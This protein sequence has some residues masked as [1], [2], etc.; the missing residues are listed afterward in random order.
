MKIHQRYYITG[1][2]Q[3]VWFR[4]S[5]QKKALELNLCGIVKNQADG[6]VYVEVEGTPMV[7]HEFREWCKQGPEHARVDQLES[8]TGALKN[9]TSFEILR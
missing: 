9:Y 4:A 8:Q 6:S 7:L 2:V 1:K 3:G 5:T